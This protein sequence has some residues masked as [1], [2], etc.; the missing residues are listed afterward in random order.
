VTAEDPAAEALSGVSEHPG[1][2]ASPDL[3]PVAVELRRRRKLLGLSQAQVAERAGVARQVVNEIERGHRIPELRTY[4]KLRGL[5][6]LAPPSSVLTRPRPP[7]RWPDDHLTRLCAC[8]LA[9]RGV[10]LADLADALD[11]AIP[12]VREG[13]LAL[14]DRLASVG[15][16]A[17]EDGA[18]VRVEPV[19]P[20]AAAVGKVTTLEAV[21]RPSEEQLAV[22]M[23]VAYL[24]TATRREVERWRDEDSES[25][26]DRLV[27]KGFLE[28]VRDTAPRAPNVFR[29]TTAALAACGFP[30]LEALQ[31]HLASTLS[32]RDVARINAL[33]SGPSTAQVSVGVS[34]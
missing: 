14:S 12:A 9:A 6:G 24:G 32:A 22:L 31:A 3:P 20:V 5:L 29:L 23:V 33:A 19:P 25:L 18:V 7:Q 28:K 13:L 11:V 27:A 26:L 34:P 1:P 17:W 15:F 10:T 21:G 30:T 2:P 4:E 8:V 16:R